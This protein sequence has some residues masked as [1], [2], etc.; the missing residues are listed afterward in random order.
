MTDQEE[1]GRPGNEVVKSQTIRLD[2]AHFENKSFISCTLVYGGGLP[3]TLINCDFIKSR[4]AF[5]GAALNTVNFMNSMVKGGDG[6][7][8]L[9][10]QM[11]GL[12]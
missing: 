6:G 2:Y 11:L 8:A 1:Q 9:I 10:N 4:F 12:T 7:R 5:E 3:P